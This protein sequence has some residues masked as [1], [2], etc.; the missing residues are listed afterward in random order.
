MRDSRGI[1]R[2]VGAERRRVPGASLVEF[3][4]LVPLL[5]MLLLGIITA[6]LALATK[7]SMTNAVREAARLGETL[8]PPDDAAPWNWDRDWAVPVKDRVVHLAAGDLKDAEV[9][10]QLVDVSKPGQ[11]VSSYPSSGCPLAMPTPA[12]PASAT[13]CVVKVWAKRTATLSIFLSAWQLDL[14]AKAVGRFE[15]DRC[16]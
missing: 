14:E 3:A 10:V 9:C 11:P 2:R 7:N 15:L 5:F 13:G 8:A 6:G 16:A 1:T 4:L 12:T